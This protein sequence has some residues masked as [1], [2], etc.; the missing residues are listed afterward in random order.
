MIATS[1]ATEIPQQHIPCRSPGDV[2]FLAEGRQAERRGWRRFVER[3][4]CLVEQ[5]ALVE[6]RQTDCP[7]P[8]NPPGS[9]AWQTPCVTKRPAP[10]PAPARHPP[11]TP[12][13]TPAGAAS[14]VRLPSRHPSFPHRGASKPHGCSA[15]ATRLLVRSVRSTDA[16]V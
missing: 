2:V 6:S 10:P 3:A 8:S 4:R 12:S 15:D 11:G 9:P 16:R 1:T 7:A 13:G 5:H 14:T